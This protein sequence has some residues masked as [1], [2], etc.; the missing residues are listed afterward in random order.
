MTLNITQHD[1]V[2]RSEKFNL[3]IDIIAVAIFALPIVL[4]M[5]EWYLGLEG[6]LA[7]ILIGF[8]LLGAMT[9]W[10]LLSRNI[11]SQSKQEFFTV[12]R[13][14]G[15]SMNI[16]ILTSMF[17]QEMDIFLAI[18]AIALASFNTASYMWLK[19]PIDSSLVS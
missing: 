16:I 18:Y 9:L 7:A 11:H 4:R 10:I 19:K 14:A 3:R 13:A 1:S 5:P 6:L 17:I 2:S 15:W 12:N 8:V